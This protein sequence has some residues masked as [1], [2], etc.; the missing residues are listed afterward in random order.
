MERSRTATLSEAAEAL[1]DLLAEAGS[2]P[3]DSGQVY[4]EADGWAEEP[5]APAAPYGEDPSIAP[6]DDPAAILGA[7]AE[8]ILLA[9]LWGR[10][11]E[12]AEVARTIRSLRAVE[13][14][15]GMRLEGIISLLLAYAESLPGEPEE[16]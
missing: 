6:E 16:P 2:Y 4:G 15:Y 14:V 12:R 7:I 1:A 10:D 9:D 13:D 3:G 11:M 5:G 8:P